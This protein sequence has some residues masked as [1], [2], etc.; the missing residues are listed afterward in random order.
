M[1]LHFPEPWCSRLQAT[2]AVAV[3]QICPG[4]MVWCAPE[5]GSGQGCYRPVL[6]TYQ[7]R[8][9]AI[10]HIRYDCKSPCQGDILKLE[11]LV[12][13]VVIG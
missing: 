10:Y 8:A 1:N 11:L 13:I 2:G 5:D 4:M 12:V 3:E 6:E 7:N 9:D